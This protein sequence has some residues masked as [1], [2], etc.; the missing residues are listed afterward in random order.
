MSDKIVEK[1]P[2]AGIPTSAKLD[3]RTVTISEYSKYTSS[4]IERL[5]STFRTFKNAKIYLGGC[6]VFWL[7]A[8]WYA[9]KKA[10]SDLF[11]S[12]CNYFIK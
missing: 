8:A 6:I 1:N 11:G 5:N 10:Y 4:E 12:D 9:N 7:A 3:P 2:F